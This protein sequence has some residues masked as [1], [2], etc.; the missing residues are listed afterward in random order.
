MPRL[1]SALSFFLGSSLLAG[2][3]FKTPPLVEIELS[4]PGH[5]ATLR[6]IVGVY[7]KERVCYLESVAPASVLHFARASNT[8][9][10]EEQKVWEESVT[11]TIRGLPPQQVVYVIGHA[12]R[13]EV[14]D[15]AAAI[16][17]GMRRAQAARSLIVKRGIPIERLQVL[18]RGSS[19][20]VLLPGESQR[21][22]EWRRASV[23][24]TEDPGSHGARL[25]RKAGDQRTLLAWFQA[26]QKNSAESPGREPFEAGHH[27][28]RLRLQINEGLSRVPALPPV[29]PSAD[30]KQVMRL[31]GELTRNDCETQMLESAARPK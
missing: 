30:A 9:R 7:E 11:A 23:Q 29:S 15:E 24:L 2:T 5:Q 8:P 4:S 16:S 12:E 20:S 1:I 27:V 21:A 28:P 18:S 6:T 22:A 13:E 14:K 10:S 31:M 3:P 26:A 17:L 19:E 25:I